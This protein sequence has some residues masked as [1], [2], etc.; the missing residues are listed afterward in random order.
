MEHCADFGHEMEQIEENQ[1]SDPENILISLQFACLNRIKFLKLK[2]PLEKEHLMNVPE[3][4]RLQVGI[5]GR[6]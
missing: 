5:G 2:K 6:L 3:S 4:N 1:L